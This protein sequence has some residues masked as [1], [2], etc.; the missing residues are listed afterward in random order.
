MIIPIERIEQMILL[1]RGEKVMLDSD[2]AKLYG[3]TTFNLNKAVRRNPDRFPDDFM[4]QLTQRGFEG[5][6]FQSGISSRHGGRR[7]RPYVFTEQG[8]AMLSG[9]LQSLR[10]VAVNVA[11]MRTFVRFRRMLASH[12]NLSRR[13]D[14]LEKKCDAQFK[15]VFE[16]IREWIEP[17][18]APP[19][20]IGF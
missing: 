18:D 6:I 1:I 16:T 5:L 11:I 15:V 12:R 13:L 17:P 14:E 2:L 20:R 9:V 19:K 3:V 10:A 7:H 4:F 8:I